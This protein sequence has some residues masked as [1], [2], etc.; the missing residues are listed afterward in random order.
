MFFDPAIISTLKLR[1]KTKN[2]GE[3]KDSRGLT[4]TKERNAENS[5]KRRNIAFSFKRQA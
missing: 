2:P 3:E 1:E 4:L 5:R